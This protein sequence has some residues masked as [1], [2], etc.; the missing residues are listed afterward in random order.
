MAVAPTKINVL[1]LWQYA[2]L[3]KGAKE[4]NA[5]GKTFTVRSSL[6]LHVD[7]ND[8]GVAYT[9]K[10]DHVALTQTPQQA[11]EVL[12]VHCECTN[13]QTSTYSNARVHVHTCVREGKI[14]K[15][16]RCIFTA[17]E[18]DSTLK[19]IIRIIC[20]FLATHYIYRTDFSFIILLYWNIIN[21]ITF[22][23]YISSTSVSGWHFRE[24]YFK[25]SFNFQQ[26]WLDE[27]LC[28]RPLLIGFW[29]LV[30]CDN[31]MCR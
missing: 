1:H 21:L 3:S 23:S 28:L 22:L 24:L 19:D 29:T 2:T 12:E 6:Q 31:M 9:C 27:T 4:V 16:E 13:T 10:V 14:K 11:T 17:A 18:L 5:S 8:D 20:L 15:H 30:N 26:T 7:R 25:H